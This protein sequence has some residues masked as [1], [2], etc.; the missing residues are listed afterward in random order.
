MTDSCGQGGICMYS[1]WG[2]EDRG[3]SWDGSGEGFPL[4]NP[5]RYLRTDLGRGSAPIRIRISYMKCL[6]VHFK[7]SF[8]RSVCLTIVFGIL[9]AHQIKGT[10]VAHCC[11]ES[12]FC[13]IR[14]MIRG[15]ATI[16]NDVWI[17]FSEIPVLQ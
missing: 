17:S 13:T 4:P 12:A 9:D 6:F 5:P 3:T 16:C 10:Y 8:G 15:P 7:H 2:H 11:Y 1:H 14:Q